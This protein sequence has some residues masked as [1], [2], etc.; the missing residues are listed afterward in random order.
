MGS[1]IRALKPITGLLRS[2]GAAGLRRDLP[3]L[4]CALPNL[5]GGVMKPEQSEGWPERQRSY[6]D[7]FEHRYLA[8]SAGGRYAEN[9]TAKL[10]SM[11]GSD[12]SRRGSNSAAAPDASRFRCW[13]AAAGW[14]PWTSPKRG[15]AVASRRSG[16]LRRS[17]GRREPREKP[18]NDPGHCDGGRRDDPST[19][20]PRRFRGHGLGWPQ[21]RRTPPVA[22]C[23]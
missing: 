15:S 14:T 21:A 22:R 8:P 5:P 9:I 16:R 6:Y 23:A 7:R 12:A 11:L 1:E 18:E 17:K 10:W 2:G 3:C 4:P 13:R 19:V 20:A